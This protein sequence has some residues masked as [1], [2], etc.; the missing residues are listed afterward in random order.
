MAVMEEAGEE[1]ERRKGACP[2]AIRK[3]NEEKEARN[4][5]AYM[6]NISGWYVESTA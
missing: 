4:D 1:E 6:Q 3:F 5:L 2:N